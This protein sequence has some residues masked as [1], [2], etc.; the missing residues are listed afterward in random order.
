MTGA[1]S[2]K[3]TEM[4]GAVSGKATEMT[5]TVETTAMEE[6]PSTYIVKKGDSLFKIGQKYNISWKKLA[7]ENNIE[8]PDSIHIGQEI[9]IP[10]N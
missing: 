8:D 10:Q 6:V 2:K 9:K 4:T 3:A 5:G 7:E 1:V